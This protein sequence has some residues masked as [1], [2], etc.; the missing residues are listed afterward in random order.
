MEG[1]SPEQIAVSIIMPSYNSAIYIRES[2]EAIINQ[3]FRDWELLITDDCSTDNSVDIIMG[4]VHRD[5]RV[6]FFTLAENSGAGVARNNSIREARGRFIA[7]CDSDDLWLADKLERQISFM[8]SGGYPFTY[9]DYYTRI[10][11]RQTTR[12]IKF[13]KR[14]SYN[15]LLSNSIGCLT[16]I[17]DTDYFGKVYMP[18]IRKRQ[19]WA[20]W[21]TL[22]RK[23]KYAYGI[24]QPLA[25]YRIRQDSISS[26]KL[27]LIKYNI[28]VYRNILGYSRIKSYAI[29]SC[30]F[31]PIYALKKVRERLSI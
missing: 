5:S 19:D 20:L 10:E 18:D 24:P 4:Y 1:K 15:Y 7:F 25:V 16:A 14:I 22:I 31:A 13:P 30:L 9:S 28:H 8:L 27:R 12:V 3:T 17:Y 21:L 23:C 6:R 11:G 2:I 26:S 29:F